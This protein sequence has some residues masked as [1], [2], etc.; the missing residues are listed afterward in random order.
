M[1]GDKAILGKILTLLQLGIYDID[2]IQASFPTLLCGAIV[3]RVFIPIHPEARYPMGPL[4]RRMPD[5]DT[6]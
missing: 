1:Q 4:A 3:G 2:Y 5:C 6:R